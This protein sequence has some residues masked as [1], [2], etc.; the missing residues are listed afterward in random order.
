MSPRGDRA[1]FIPASGGKNLN[2]PNA[3]KKKQ[4]HRRASSQTSRE[5]PRR[6]GPQWRDH[7]QDRRSARP[8][9]AGKGQER[10]A[11]LAG[12]DQVA[13]AGPAGEPGRR[14]ESV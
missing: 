4:R 1:A 6:P 5:R 12:G 7:R 9:S 14:H 13:S 10:P 11:D 8:L 3:L 2:N